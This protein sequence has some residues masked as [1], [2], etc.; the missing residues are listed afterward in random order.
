MKFTDG[1][2][3]MRQGVRVYYPAQTYEVTAMEAA[4]TVHAPVKSIRNR[5]DTLDGPLLTLRCSSPL[6][7]VRTRSPFVWRTMRP[8]SPAGG[9]PFRWQEP[10]AG[11]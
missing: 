3:M 10:E 9:S 8:R 11:K 6:P 1:N 7:D 5:G 2:W 4:L